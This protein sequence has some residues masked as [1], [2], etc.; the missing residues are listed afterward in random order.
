[1]PVNLQTCNY[2]DYIIFKHH[3]DLINHGEFAVDSRSSSLSTVCTHGLHP[4]VKQTEKVTY[5]E[6]KWGIL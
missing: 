3:L 4:I 2:L 1:M 6:L 5:K